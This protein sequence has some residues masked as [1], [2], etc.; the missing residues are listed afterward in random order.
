MLNKK[1]KKEFFKYGY[2]VLKNTIKKEKI[3]FLLKTV[4]NILIEANQHSKNKKFIKEIDKNYLYLK[5][6]NRNLKS[7]LYDSFKKLENLNNIFQEKNILNLVKEIFK[8]DIIIDNTQI[9]I[10][11]PNN[12]RILDFHQELH[13]QSLI[14]IT[15]W[16]PLR[17]LN[18]E[19]GGLEII[20]GSHKKGYLEHEN[21]KKKDIQQKLI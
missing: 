12:D 14:N 9:R 2:V 8:S 3:N 20:E 11:D 6:N 19:I 4:N 10:D 16:A 18:K 1:I 13:Q 17:K 21:I 15:A 7:Q 5:E